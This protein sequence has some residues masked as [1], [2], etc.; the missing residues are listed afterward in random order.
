M[1][2]QT[3]PLLG[4]SLAILGIISL[5]GC[6]NPSEI[7]EEVRFTHRRPLETNLI[8]KWIPTSATLK[9]MRD[10]G[11]YSITSH[12]LDLSADGTFSITNMPD[13]WKT[14]FGESR[15]VLESASGTWRV[16]QDSGGD[17]VIDLS[18]GTAVIQSLHLRNQESPI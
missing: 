5:S 18:V 11:G 15:K 1:S 10:E 6:Y 12:E 3:I 9:D 7:A 4:M 2:V 17:W 16:S 8:G 14:P 13:W